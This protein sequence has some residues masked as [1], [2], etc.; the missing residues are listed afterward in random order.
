MAKGPLPPPGAPGPWRKARNRRG[1]RRGAAF[2]GLLSRP[3]RGARLGPHSSAS[4]K[5]PFFP[6][7]QGAGGKTAKSAF[8]RDGFF[9]LQCAIGKK[10]ALRRALERGRSQLRGRQGG[11]QA[12]AHRGSSP[13]RRGAACAAGSPGNLRDGGPGGQGAG[14]APFAGKPRLWVTFSPKKG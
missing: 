12:G 4:V 10:A 3:R 8:R 6:K 9:P 11:W 7:G 5:S 1:G 2:P 14:R 13:C